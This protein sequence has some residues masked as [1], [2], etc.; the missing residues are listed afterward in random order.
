MDAEPFKPLA[1]VRTLVYNHAQ[2]LRDCLDGIVMQETTF[3]FIAV[4]HDD[5][6]TD[7]SAAIIREYAEKYPDIIKPIFETENLY[8]KHDGSLKRIMNEAC[9]GIKYHAVCEGDDYWTDPHKL[10]KQIS[11]LEEHP[12]CMLTVCHG[13]VL[14]EGWH[15]VCEEEYRILNW[16]YPGPEERDISLQEL[17]ERDGRFLLTAG[18]VYRGVLKEEY[19]PELVALPFGDTPLKLIAAIK[20]TIHYLPDNMVV[21]RFLSSGSS[22]TAQAAKKVVR[23]FSDIPWRHVVDMYDALDSYCKGKHRDI[24]RVAALKNAMVF[25]NRYPELQNEIV[26][27]WKKIF[28][29]NY[30]KGA[31][32][33]HLKH[34]QNGVVSFILRLLYYPHYPILNAP[35]LLNSTLRAYCR[36]YKSGASLRIKRKHIMTY[37]WTEKKFRFYFFGKKLYAF[38]SCQTDAG[39]TE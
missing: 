31:T 8:S 28:S 9:K 24:L 7:D 37:I 38:D 32:E 17:T 22:A 18:M 11:Y 14:C 35:Y 10:Q 15:F 12:E 33:Y 16:P 39:K 20:G 29:Y 26:A 30:M 13:A 36:Q 27:A 2:F 23:C 5:A 34:N 25:V 1:V 6:S 4:V 3:P 21:Y 19:P